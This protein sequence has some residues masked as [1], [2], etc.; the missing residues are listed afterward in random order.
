MSIPRGIAND[1]YDPGA[2]ITSDT[3]CSVSAELVARKPAT[4]IIAAPG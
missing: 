4:E 3:P 2:L 1:D